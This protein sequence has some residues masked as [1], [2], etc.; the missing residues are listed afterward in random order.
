LTHFV[1]PA[2]QPSAV[3]PLR[4]V[5]AVF[6]GPPRPCTGCLAYV[7]QR[8]ASASGGNQQQGLGEVGI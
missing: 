8:P 5:S 1:R 6:V 4:Y 2:G 3:T 7:F